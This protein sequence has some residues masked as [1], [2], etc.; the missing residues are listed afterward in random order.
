[1]SA[2][3]PVLSVPG[4]NR[5]EAALEEL[6]LVVSTDIY[7]NESNKHAHYV[8]P[9]TTFLEREDAPLVFLSLFVKPFIQATEPALRPYGEA[10]QEWEVIDDIARR[11]GV[12]PYT[13]RGL[14]AFARMGLRLKPRRMLDLMIRTGRAGDRFGLRRRGLSLRKL[15]TAHPHGVVLA[16]ELPTGVLKGRIRNGDRKV[17]LWAPE[18]EAELG[19][20]SED[21]AEQADREHPLLLIGMRELR[22]HNSWMHNASLLMRARRGH[23]LLMNPSDAQSAGIVDD[24]RVVVTSRSGSIETPVSLTRDVMEGVVALPHGWGHAG[25]WQLANVNA[26]TNVNLL[27]PAAPGD[28]EPLAGMAHLNGIPVDVAPLDGQAVST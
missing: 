23:C 6:E 26:G 2:G 4:A 14:R 8:L 19:R 12:Q 18:I 24:A 16:D 27:T 22:S 5:L 11:I 13:Q 7:V 10:R 9:S 25:G 15:L 1:M 20:L 3:N 21:D 17:H 28:I